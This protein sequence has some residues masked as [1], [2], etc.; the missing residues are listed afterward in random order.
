M[1]QHLFR[2][3]P[4]REL[5]EAERRFSAVFDKVRRPEPDVQNGHANWTPAVDVSENGEGFLFT[6]ELPG[7]KPEAVNIEVKEN[8]LTIKGERPRVEAKDDVRIHHRERPSGRFARVFRLQKSV[9]AE[10]VTATYHD[11][12]LDITV[13]LR[14]EVKSRKIPV[15]GS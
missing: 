15:L 9:D 3:N 7:M 6:V 14:T 1:Q 2:W 8:V 11:G 13:P 10:R 4:M 5:A 12:L